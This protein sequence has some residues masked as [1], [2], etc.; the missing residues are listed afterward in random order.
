MIR[1]HFVVEGQAEET[2]VN[3]LLSKDL[4][5]R[6]IFPSVRC[7]LTTD[8]GSHPA[9]GGGNRYRPWRK[10]ILRTL[11]S[12]KGRDVFLTTMIDFYGLPQDFPGRDECSANGDPVAAVS[13]LEQRLRI[14]LGD[15]PRFIPYIQL[16]EYEALLFADPDVFPATFT[17]ATPD[18]IRQL[19]QIRTS[20]ST[21]DEINDGKTTAPSKRIIDVFPE[22]ERN[23]PM[24]SALL[25]IDI[26]LERMSTASPH[27][28]HWL[29]TFRNLRPLDH[30]N[31]ATT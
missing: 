17:Q 9:K 1:L 18:Q 25:A 15:D 23:K 22:Y 8:E 29:E 3:E 28:R 2:F 21:V 24:L 27:F 6:D 30:R 10:D 20:C 19:R 11:R 7:V 4:I 16:H 14:D 5:P 13:C 31:D 26:G 12:E